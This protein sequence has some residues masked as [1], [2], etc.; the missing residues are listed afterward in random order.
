MGLFHR[1]NIKRFVLQNVSIVRKRPAG[2]LLVSLPLC[3]A[4]KE[5]TEG[6]ATCIL[7]MRTAYLLLSQSTPVTWGDG[8][9][10]Q[11]NDLLDVFKRQTWVSLCLFSLKQ[12]TL[13][14]RGLTEQD[15]LFHV[16]NNKASGN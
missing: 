4:G 2:A 14:S 9:K 10:T 5:S 8:E 7:R 16:H 1:L 12:R 15:H 11:G 13:D 6:R 3:P